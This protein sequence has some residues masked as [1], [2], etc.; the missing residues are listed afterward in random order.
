MVTTPW[1]DVPPIPTDGPQLPAGPIDVCIIGAGVSGLSVAHALLAEGASVVVLE[2]NTVGGGMSSRTTAH[3]SSALDVG[4]ERLQQ[5][6]GEDGMC[7]AVQSHA[8]ALDRIERIVQDEDIACDFR[9]LDGYL[10]APPGTSPNSLAKELNLAQ[11]AGLSVEMRHRAPIVDFD[12]GPAICF[13]RQA[14]LHLVRYLA[15][16]ARIVR[17]LRGRIA[18]PVRAT[19][20]EGGAHPV[21]HLADGG[22]LAAG[23]VVMATH[24]PLGSPHPLA[25]RQEATIT[26]ALAGRVPRGSVPRALFWDTAEP[27]HY[28]RLAETADRGSEQLLIAGGEDHPA[29]EKANPDRRFA[30]VER[31]TRE[32]FPMLGAL[33]YRWSG[34]ILEPTDALAFTGRLPGESHVYVVT[35]DSG[36]GITQAAI[37]GMVIGDLILRRPSAWADLYDPSRP[38]HHE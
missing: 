8:A 30:A 25:D 3:L 17:A 38:R 10:F 1:T 21:V 29:S 4:F 9:R 32:R 14:Q 24:V 36:H 12:T 13:G 6:F 7:R 27:Y 37:A 20:V 19:R 34:M 18:A 28:V 15:G 22:R 2:A 33:A 11:K 31:W 5:L 16:L 26:Y 35:G 23:S